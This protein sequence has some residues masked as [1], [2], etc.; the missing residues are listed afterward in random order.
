MGSDCVAPTAARKGSP[1]TRV[2]HPDGSAFLIDQTEVTNA[3]YEEF[4]R[5]KPRT[6][7][8]LLCPNAPRTDPESLGGDC[9]AL[10][11][12]DAGTAADLPRVCV[13]W[14]EAE[15]YCAWAGKGMCRDTSKDLAGFALGQSSDFFAACA[16]DSIASA[17]HVYGCGAD[18]SAKDC[19][20]ED[21]SP[22][23]SVLPV[24]SQLACRVGPRD[25]PISDLS[26]NVEEWTGGCETNEPKGNC[27]VRGGSFDSLAMD[28][29]CGSKKLAMR[30]TTLPTLGFRC[31][32][33][34][35][36]G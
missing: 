18:C 19:N 16:L 9:A 36:E 11:S 12:S 13:D 34:P 2:A 7:D 32:V 26:G 14:C 27:V 30:T 25:C 28:L 17:P 4:L 20:G 3:Q 29:E 21:S 6:S 15:A 22:V 1:M 35:Y 8:A 24:G 33:D 23:P 31:C 5:T 10:L